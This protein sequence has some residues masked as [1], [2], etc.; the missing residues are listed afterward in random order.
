[1][2]SLHRATDLTFKVMD[3]QSVHKLSPPGLAPRVGGTLQV[4]LGQFP[5]QVD[6]GHSNSLGLPLQT[7]CR[8]KTVHV[9]VCVYAKKKEEGEVSHSE[10][11]QEELREY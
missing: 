8:A 7:E 9:C 6:E 10:L 5:C 3:I 4:V 1:M 2:L 11:G